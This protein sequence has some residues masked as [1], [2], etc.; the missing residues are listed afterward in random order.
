MVGTGCVAGCG[1]AAQSARE[2]NTNTADMKNFRMG[3]HSR[4][5]Q[6]KGLI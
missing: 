6:T 4:T 3:G 1:T 5:S 2:H